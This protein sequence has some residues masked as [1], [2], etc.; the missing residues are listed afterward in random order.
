[1]PKK[2]ITGVGV[3]TPLVSGSISW[4]YVASNQD[5]ARRVI[6]FLE[7][8]RVLTESPQRTDYEQC[9][10]SAQDIKNFLTLEIMNVKA[11]GPLEAWFK[12]MR[13]ACLAFDNAAGINS[14]NFIRD[15]DLF[16][17]CLRAFRDVMGKQIGSLAATFNIPLEPELQAI[18]PPPGLLE[19]PPEG[20]R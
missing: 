18:V 14:A 19:P 17:A 2:K 9:R 13:S 16:Q 20:N 11:G 6:V 4:E 8:R 3:G 7:P 15:P 1:M 12:S 5:L 10:L